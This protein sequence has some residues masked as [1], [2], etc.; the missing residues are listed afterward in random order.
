MTIFVKNKNKNKKWIW[1][2]IMQTGHKNIFI[3]LVAMFRL[4][5][6][7]KYLHC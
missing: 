5:I 7:I 2:L 6:K 1:G 4:N 3:L